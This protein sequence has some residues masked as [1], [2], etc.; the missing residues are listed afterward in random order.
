MKNKTVKRVLLVLLSV[1][2]LAGFIVFDPDVKKIDDVLAAMSPWWL[3]GALICVFIYYLGDTGMYLIGSYAMGIPQGFFQGL[4]TTMIGFFYS[5]VTPLAS[6]GQPFQVLHMRGRGINVGTATSVLMV[7][8]LAWHITITLF[9][10]V[11]FT[12]LWQDL[13][14]IGTGMTVLFCIGFCVHAFCAS[15]GVMLMIKPDFVRRAGLRVIG[16]VGRTFCKRKLDNGIP[17]MTAAYERFIADYEQAASFALQRKGCM[18]LILLVA[19]FEVL[20]YL[21]TTYF[22]YRGLGFD[23]VGYW[24]MLLMQAMLSIAVAFIPLPGASGASEGGF[25]ALF[26]QFF[27]GA[28]L[29]AMLIWRA[30]T[31][32]L[33][34]LLGLI[35]VVIDGFQKKHGRAD[36]DVSC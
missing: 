32:Y 20:A 12:L 31:Y 3:A 8:F 30:L 23:K 26:T 7:K 25:Y 18:L 4:L 5:A 15:L 21:S 13:A 2:V 6:G 35:A 28:R 36:K 9:G 19:F 29:P 17:G 27:D 10:L 16:W 22:I 24:T 33:T 11:G 1:A 34:I 14:S